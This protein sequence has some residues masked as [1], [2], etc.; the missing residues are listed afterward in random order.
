MLVR[1]RTYFV[2][3][4]PQAFELLDSAACLFVGVIPCPDR[5]HTC[6]FVSRVALRTVV[7]VRIGT[8]WAVSRSCW[9]TSG[10]AAIFTY[11]QMLPVMAMCGHLCGLHITATTAIPLAVRIGRA[12]SF[13]SKAFL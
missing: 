9:Y 5:T 4:V 7:K 10:R 12:F 6:G 13:G 3:I 2:H 11:T 1:D 8:S